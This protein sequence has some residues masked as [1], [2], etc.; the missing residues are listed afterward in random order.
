M[1]STL[2]IFIEVRAVLTDEEEL[3]LLEAKEAL[4]QGKKVKQRLPIQEDPTVYSK[5]VISVACFLVVLGLLIAV[6]SLVEYIIRRLQLLQNLLQIHLRIV[7]CFGERLTS[8]FAVFFLV[9]AKFNKL[10]GKR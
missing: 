9:L 6:P 4:E 3:R 2:S 8:C 7:S 10:E 5:R 1:F